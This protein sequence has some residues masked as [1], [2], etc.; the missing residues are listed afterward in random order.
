MPSLSIVENRPPDSLAESVAAVQM[1]QNKIEALAATRARLAEV[2]A[3]ENSV[4]SEVGKIGVREVEL[5]RAWAVA[6]GADLAPDLLTSERKALA[7]RLALAQAKASGV[8]KAIADIDGEIF[9]L[10][11]EARELSAAVDVAVFDRLSDDYRVIISE[12]AK[13]FDAARQKAAQAF[14]LRQAL[15]ARANEMRGEGKDELALSLMRGLEKLI[16]PDPEA[17][18]SPTIGEV[19]AAQERAT[20]RIRQLSEVSQ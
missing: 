15:Y 12:C 7:E 5:F 17:A 2:L 6:G 18:A 8:E 4:L 9:R 14:G 3:E 11:V 13:A 16:V 1:V 20:Q 19:N 10:S